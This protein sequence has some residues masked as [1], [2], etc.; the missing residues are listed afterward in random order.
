MIKEIA[1]YKGYYVSDDGIIYSDKSGEL[2]ALHPWADSR[3]LYLMVQFSE[4]NITYKKL[5]HRL[6]AET[7][8]PNPNNY[9]EVNHINYNTQDNRVENL[10]W[11][12]RLYNVHHMLQ[13]Y[14]PVRNYR[15]CKLF[16]K[17]EYINDF[18]SVCEAARYANKN[19]GASYTGLIRNLKSKQAEIIKINE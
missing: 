12:T 15:E 17:D 16:Y 7:F 18:R 14:S 6:I 3:G 1:D 11:C 19:F 4:N 2:K 5:V 9:P 13:K 8:I 10:E